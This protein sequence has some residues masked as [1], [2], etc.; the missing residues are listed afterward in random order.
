MLTLLKLKVK[1]KIIAKKTKEFAQAI[2]GNSF[3][4]FLLIALI[5]LPFA[6]LNL[7]GWYEF[8]YVIFGVILFLMFLAKHEDYM[9]IAFALFIIAGIYYVDVGVMPTTFNNYKV[10]PIT[11][12]L[13]NF[14]IFFSFDF[15]LATII[16]IILFYK[17]IESYEERDLKT[18]IED[19]KHKTLKKGISQGLTEEDKN[20]LKQLDE[21]KQLI[22]GEDDE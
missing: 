9:I 4:Q 18:K 12:P 14:F 1:T 15:M 21:T 13:T 17:P 20:W 16:Y 6:Y 8:F 3:I 2:I 10:V 22:E 7:K 11:N 19:E 5:L